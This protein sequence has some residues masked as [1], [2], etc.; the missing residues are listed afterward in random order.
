MRQKRRARGGNFKILVKRIDEANV[1]D[2]SANI[3]SKVRILK[4]VKNPASRDYE[5]R[6]VVTKGAIIETERGNAIV[7]SRPG[8]H[9]VVNALLLK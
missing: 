2:P 9:G 8:Q 1:F 6:R 3:A 7:V 5:R 4:V